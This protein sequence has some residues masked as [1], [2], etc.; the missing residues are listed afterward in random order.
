LTRSSLEAQHGIPLLLVAF[1]RL[2]LC[3]HGGATGS[4]L[5]VHGPCRC[6]RDS[7]FDAELNPLPKN[8]SIFNALAWCCEDTQ[9]QTFPVHSQMA[10]G[11]LSIPATA[12]DVVRLFSAVKLTLSDQ[13]GRVYAETLGLLQLLKSWNRSR[14]FRRVWI[15]PPFD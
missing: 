10:R 15:A 11:V 6:L 13:C 9:C 4:L 8:G 14:I 12:A 2:L 1:S 3:R 7:D 5:R